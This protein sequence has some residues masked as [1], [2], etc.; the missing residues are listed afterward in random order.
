MPKSD[1][2]DETRNNAL[3]EP[4]T[5]AILEQDRRAIIQ[6]YGVDVSLVGEQRRRIDIEDPLLRAGVPTKSGVGSGGS[7][8][9][10]DIGYGAGD[11]LHEHEAAD[12]AGS[13]DGDAVGVTYAELCGNGAPLFPDG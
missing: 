4:S 7:D 5:Q 9:F 1:Y 13:P 2:C 11:D 8:G 12:H 10:V 6:R 3:R